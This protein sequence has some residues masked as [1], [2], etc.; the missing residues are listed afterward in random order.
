MK[1][2]KKNSD[3]EK[4][5]LNCI[6]LSLKKKINQRNA[7]TLRLLDYAKEIIDLDSQTNFSKAATVVDISSKVLVCRVDDIYFNACRI[8]DIMKSLK[9][10]FPFKK[11]KHVWKNSLL[12]QK[13]TILKSKSFHQTKNLVF[14]QNSKILAKKDFGKTLLLDSAIQEEGHLI[15]L[16]SKKIKSFQKKP[17]ESRYNNIDENS[18]NEMLNFLPVKNNKKMLANYPNANLFTTKRLIISS[19][20]KFLKER[21]KESYHSK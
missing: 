20:Q 5:Y 10:K 6:K 13:D 15:F 11:K 17:F 7:W 19:F 12:R 2:E 18:L 3:L 9:N 8:L 4:L 1:E 21:E 16:F 14:T